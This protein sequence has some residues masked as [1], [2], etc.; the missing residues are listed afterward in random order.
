MSFNTGSINMN[1][2]L[3]VSNGVGTSGQFLASGGSGG[4]LT[5]A[6]GG[7]GA[8]INT[9]TIDTIAGTTT[10]TLGGTNATSIA[11][12]EPVTMSGSLGVTG[13]MTGTGGIK[14][15]II[16]AVN[17][18]V[19]MDIGGNLATN[20]AVSIGASGGNGV[21]TNLRGGATTTSTNGI[22]SNYFDNSQTETLRIGDVTATSIAIGRGGVITTIGGN[23]TLSSTLSVSGGVGTAGQ[24]L[25][26]RGAGLTPIWAT[27]GTIVQS[28]ETAVGDMNFLT[29][30]ITYSSYATKPKIQLTMNLNGTGTTIIPVAVSSHT[31]TGPYTGFTWIADTT[32]ATAT[33]SWYA[34]V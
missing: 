33:I 18:A 22:K 26:S 12:N 9:N 23:L 19:V 31:G 28:G 34:T 8:S 7:I 16:E 20:R 13:I 21:A 2:I 24:V 29:G 1:G 32:S 4:S 3:T 11:L 10:L 17:T 14:A 27:N 6:T 15:N 5:W 30:T 25:A